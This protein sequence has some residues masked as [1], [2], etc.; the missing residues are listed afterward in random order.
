MAKEFAKKFYKSKSWK[1]CRQSFID[2]RIL[3]DGGLCQVCCD[4]TGYIVHHKTNLNQYNIDNPDI[5][6]NHDL[7]MYVCKECHDEFEG[8]GFK[9]EKKCSCC[10]DKYGNPI[11]KE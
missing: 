1:L 10:F 7:L 8:H 3:I 11:P 6:L 2:Q 4:K 9:K 5:T